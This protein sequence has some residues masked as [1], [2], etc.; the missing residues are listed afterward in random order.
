[1]LSAIFQ[2][3]MV[4]FYLFT[5]QDVQIYFPEIKKTLGRWPDAVNRE[6]YFCIATIKFPARLVYFFCVAKEGAEEE[7][8]PVPETPQVA[9]FI[10]A[11][12]AAPENRASSLHD[13][14]SSQKDAS[15]KLLILEK[16]KD[17]QP[18]FGITGYFW[19]NGRVRLYDGRHRASALVATGETVIPV[20][21]CV[22][23]T[24]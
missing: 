5:K 4:L 19:P 7:L 10:K 13:I 1:V 14:V 17:E 20:E 12:R 11:L 22:W 18:L 9:A 2:I 21:I 8:L 15:N 16:A 6:T 3:F 24:N 23:F